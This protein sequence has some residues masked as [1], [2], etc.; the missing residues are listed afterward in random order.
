M[1]ESCYFL[2]ERAA[3]Q[4]GCAAGANFYSVGQARE[5][6]RTCPLA[7]LGDA[8]FCEHMIVYT[9]RE[10]K[11][12]NWVIWAEVECNLDERAS[13]DLRCAA[14]PISGQLVLTSPAEAAALA[15]VP[16]HFG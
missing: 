5:V 2:K 11:Q 6:C 12:G 10:R 14:C 1:K 16:E 3:G 13:S 9:Y 7:D 15:I 4:L 8:P